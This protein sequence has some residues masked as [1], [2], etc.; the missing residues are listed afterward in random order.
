MKKSRLILCSELENVSQSKKIMNSC[1]YTGVYNFDGY[2][3]GCNEPNNLK[4]L[5]SYLG[6]KDLAYWNKFREF[7]DSLDTQKKHCALK[8]VGNDFRPKFVECIAQTVPGFQ[9]PMLRDDVVLPEKTKA[10]M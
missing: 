5:D 10:T 7:W 3:H 1:M 9:V 4:S 8:A 2:S 6:H